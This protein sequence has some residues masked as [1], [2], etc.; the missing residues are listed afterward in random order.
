M[1]KKI[2]LKRKI[3]QAAAEVQ[4]KFRA[5]KKVNLETE[6]A[7]EKKWRGLVA[8]LKNI[9]EHQV[10]KTDPK[11]EAKTEAY[12]NQ[13]ISF[14]ED[15]S[16]LKMDDG[17]QCFFG[18]SSSY[19]T[20]LPQLTPRITQGSR[21][22]IPPL[23]FSS[24]VISNVY[25]NEPEGSSISQALD[26]SLL[27]LDQNPIDFMTDPKL[28]DAFADFSSLHGDLAARYII[29]IISD[30]ESHDQTFGVTFHPEENTFYLGRVN[31]DFENDGT[32][33]FPNNV[34][35]AGTPGLYELLFLAS[36]NMQ[37]IT[38]SDLENYKKILLIT[39]IHR[40]GYRE[41]GRLRSSKNFKYKKIIAPL[42]T[43]KG[44]KLSHKT[45][46]RYIL[47]NDKPFNNLYYSDVNDLV[48]R[49][50]ILKEAEQLG[51]TGLSPEIFSIEK[52]LRLNNLIL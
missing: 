3:V 17:P 28:K 20:P 18:P 32:L 31:I 40:V 8:P 6:R 23:T 49:L 19:S 7:E 37:K 30:R 9:V 16:G 39:N 5:L 29:K 15:T 51:N 45:K 52:E 44:G 27:N 11:K 21:R 36:P 46:D 14:D 33:H 25:E 4:K 1:S 13:D 47:L 24:P 50:Q 34:V 43:K 26:A 22:T 38:Q 48:K 41:K 2:Q 35:F 10:P 12:S 42:F